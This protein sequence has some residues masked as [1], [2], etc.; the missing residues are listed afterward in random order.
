VVL[1]GTQVTLAPLLVTVLLG[2]LAVSV[3]RRTESGC[4]FAGWVTGYTV[5]CAGLAGWAQLG[6]T[7]APVWRATVAGLF[8]AL[9]VG[10]CGRYWEFGWSALPD[11]WQRVLRA[12]AAAVACYVLVSAVL[13]AVVLAAHVHQIEA[14]QNRV[15]PG[16]A[17]LPVGLLGIAAAP[18]AAIAG[19]GYL[20]GPGFQIGTHTSISMFDVVH[21]RLPIFPMLAG[22]PIGDPATALGVVL[23]ML[24][25]LAAGALVYRAVRVTEDVLGVLSDAAA[26]SALTGV[27][28]AVLAEL[29]GGGVGD[30]ALRSVG[31]TWWALGCAS[32]ATV[33]IGA[34]LWLAVGLAR[35]RMSGRHDSGHRGVPAV[36]YRPKPAAKV[37]TLPARKAG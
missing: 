21:G 3:A 18:N 23:G 31:A 10:G 20:A 30:G 29:A 37:R 22:V 4:A 26:A 2:W 35:R 8:F 5:G 34:A 12:T 24:T 36:P 15:S 33:L 17:G 19:V 16:A 9:V 7:Y 1:E 32:L 25:M 28:F 13:V 6:Q 27:A 11:R 14:I